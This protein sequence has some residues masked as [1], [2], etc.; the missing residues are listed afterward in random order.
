[1]VEINDYPNFTDEAAEA[2]LGA[3]RWHENGGKPICPK[4]GGVSVYRLRKRRAF[5]CV[6]CYHHYSVTTGTIFHGHKL[7]FSSCV[8]AMLIYENE[9]KTLTNVDL[10]RRLNL[11][12]KTASVLKMKLWEGYSSHTG[13]L[14]EPSVIARGYWQGFNSFSVDA[15]GNMIRENSK[16]ER[17]VNHSVTE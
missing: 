9:H 10:A 11:N 5:K 4:C 15:E 14:S 1:M 13:P 8:K 2:V 3:L 12:Y 17:K 7:S 16:G 6:D